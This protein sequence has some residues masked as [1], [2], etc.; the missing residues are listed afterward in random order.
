M[1]KKAQGAHFLKGFQEENVRKNEPQPRKTTE[2]REIQ[3]LTFL[4]LSFLIVFFCGSLLKRI[5]TGHWK[6]TGRMLEK[7]LQKTYTWDDE[8]RLFQEICGGHHGGV[9]DSL[10]VLGRDFGKKTVG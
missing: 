7:F 6:A 2:L 1:G 10:G 9:R 5:K 3:G 4:V 8:Q